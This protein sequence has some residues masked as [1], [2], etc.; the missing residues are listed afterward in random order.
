MI[1]YIASAA[2]IA[3]GLYILIVKSN[4]IKMILGISIVDSGVNL[5]LISIGYVSGGTAPIISG[6]VSPVE[7][8]DPLPQAL[9]L[10]NIVIGVSV[11]ALALAVIIK[12]YSYY[13]TLNSN[14]VRDMKW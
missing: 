1:F 14:E 7:F 9:V 10:T 8:V 3:I 2:L 13:K 5:L 12:V 6:N 4:L 11:T